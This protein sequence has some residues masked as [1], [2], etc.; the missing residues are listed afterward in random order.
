MLFKKLSTILYGLRVFCKSCSIKMSSMIPHNVILQ[1][2]P[3]AKWDQSRRPFAVASGISTIKETWHEIN[4]CVGITGTVLMN[5]FSWQG[6][7]LT[8]FDI[9]HWLEICDPQIRHD[10]LRSC[11]LKSSIS[12]LRPRRPET[13]KKQVVEYVDWF[14]M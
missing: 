5:P 4:G 10:I 9:H 1:L 2:I 12:P 11:V 6:Q 8:G 3:L 7:N 13:L 14:V